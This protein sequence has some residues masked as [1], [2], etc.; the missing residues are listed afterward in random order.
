[1]EFLKQ[2]YF[3]SEEMD[4]IGSTLNIV[5]GLVPGIEKCKGARLGGGN[6]DGLPEGSGQEWI[7]GGAVDMWPP[8]SQ[9]KY[10]NNPGNVVHQG[11]DT[12]FVFQPSTY[13]R[14]NKDIGSSGSSGCQT[15]WHRRQQLCPG[16]QVCSHGTTLQATMTFEKVLRWSH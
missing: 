3:T 12:R 11:R 4:T 7:A 16:R 10:Q 15:L 6:I 5:G 13:E 9:W 8:G 14:Q 2:E 1:M